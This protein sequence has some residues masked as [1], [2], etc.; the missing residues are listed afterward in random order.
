ME[1]NDRQTAMKTI[2]CFNFGCKWID[3]KTKFLYDMTAKA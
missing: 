2:I 3:V 1:Q